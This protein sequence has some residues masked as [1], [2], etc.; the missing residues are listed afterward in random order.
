MVRIVK[1]V[2]LAVALAS[3]G[4]VAHAAV[5]APHARPG[6]LILFE[7]RNYLGDDVSV[8]KDAP[9]VSTNWDVGS[10]AIYPGETW[11]LCNKPVYRGTCITLTESVPDASKIGI[12]GQVPSIRKMP[13]AP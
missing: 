11:Q 6:E 9:S 7:Q 1:R 8:L 2:T 3:V 5:R 10:I 13:K 4:M 12:M